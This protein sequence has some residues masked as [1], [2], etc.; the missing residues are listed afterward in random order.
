[1]TFSLK[2]NRSKFVFGT[3]A[4]ALTLTSTTAFFASAD[5]AARLGQRCTR[6]GVRSGSLTCVRKSGRLV[7]TARTVATTKARAKPVAG[8]VPTK[9][10]AA[11]APG[12]TKPVSPQPA[13]AP[14]TRGPALPGQAAPP[15]STAVT[16][17]TTPA[18]PTPTTTKAPV[19]STPA[20]STAT[21][22]PTVP[23]AAS[24]TVTTAVAT[25]TTAAPTPSTAPPL[26][27][28][29][30]IEGAW[31]V[32]SGEVGYR[33]KQ[34]VSGQSVEAVGRTKNV[35]GSMTMENTALRS[36]EMSVATTTFKSE[37]ADTKRDSGVQSVLETA[38]FPTATI[39]L[40]A[41][42]DLGQ[43][44]ADKV[45]ISKSAT[46]KLTLH[47]VAKNITIPIKA[48]RNG[49]TIEIVGSTTILFADFGIAD[50][51][52]RPLLISEDRGVVE[53]VVS[54]VR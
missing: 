12:T 30:P 36:V 35:T 45:E 42:V 43:I 44:P 13:A 8:V 32:N 11:A 38:K 20:A 51:S 52:R 33:V 25:T 19:A 31:K 18:N 26:P 9:P 23:V 4:L 37:P 50:P 17:P 34:T 3:L 6:T 2:N 1:M 14:A 5:A 49:A 15:A 29:S 54:L 21:A 47:G 10:K 39:S 7:W 22:Q 48:R 46:F 40:A 53:F 41:P 16:A 24:P 28:V 27:G